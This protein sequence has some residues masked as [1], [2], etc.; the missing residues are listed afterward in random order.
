MCRAN[1]A[2]QCLLLFLALAP[3]LTWA[4][5]QW[6][7]REAMADA[8]V[9]MMDAMGMFNSSP[10]STLSSNPFATPGPFGGSPWAPGYG[11]YGMPWMGSRGASSL[12]GIW[13]GRDGELVVV[14]GERF[15]IYSSD[16]RTLDG[17]VRVQGDRLAMHVPGEAQARAFQF[18][19]SQGRLVLR[20][21]DGQVYLYRRLRLDG[22]GPGARFPGLS[23]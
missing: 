4:E 8:M 12:Q 22:Q 7:S 23:R 9:R 14:Q 2:V 20:D 5:G 16:G 17:R 11:G 21:S 6:G 13:E 10:G 15:R 3:S 19:E 18:A 1:A